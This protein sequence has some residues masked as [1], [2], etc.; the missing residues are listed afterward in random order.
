LYLYYIIITA[1]EIKEITKNY[2]L[3]FGSFVDKTVAPYIQV[4]KK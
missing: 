3:G 4:N 2:E 1:D